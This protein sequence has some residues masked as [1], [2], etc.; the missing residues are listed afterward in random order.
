MHSSEELLGESMMRLSQL[1]RSAAQF[2][3]TAEGPQPQPSSSSSTAPSETQPRAA[4]AGSAALPT[5]P[6][7]AQPEAQ[8]QQQEEAPSAE[9]TRKLG[10]DTGLPANLQNFWFP[11]EFSSRLQA[12]AM[13]PLELFHQRW[14][15]FRDSAGRA[16]CIRDT[17]AHRACPLSLGQVVDGE[18]FTPWTRHEQRVGL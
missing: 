14:V 5:S 17:C 4:H 13:V 11:A 1:E 10:A 16:S 9:A 15:L 8:Q 6:A 3:F 18:W 2:R 7:L 12:G